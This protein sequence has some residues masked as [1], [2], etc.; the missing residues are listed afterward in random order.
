MLLGERPLS[1]PE[2]VLWELPRPSMLQPQAPVLLFGGDG[3]FRRGLLRSS[4]M[5]LSFLLPLQWKLMFV[6]RERYHAGSCACDCV[7]QWE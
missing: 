4:G 1:V 5:F 3:M 6:E 2:M 7:A